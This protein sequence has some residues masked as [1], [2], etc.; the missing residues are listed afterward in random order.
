MR[1]ENGARG[2]LSEY[3]A[4]FFETRFSGLVCGHSIC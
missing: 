1:E 3:M 2:V 4:M